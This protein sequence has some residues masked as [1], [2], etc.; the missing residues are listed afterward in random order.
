MPRQWQLL[1]CKRVH[2][3]MG[4]AAWAFADSLGDNATGVLQ[5]AWC[6]SVL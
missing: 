3:N 5:L 4:A 6:R 1:V 2:S